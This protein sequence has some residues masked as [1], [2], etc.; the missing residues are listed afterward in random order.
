M[1]SVVDTIV[2]EIAAV[3]RISTENPNDKS[4]ENRG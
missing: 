2:E 1:S 3:A 4:S